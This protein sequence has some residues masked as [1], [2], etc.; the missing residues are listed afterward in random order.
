MSSTIHHGGPQHAGH[1][2]LPMQPAVAYP[3]PMVEDTRLAGHQMGQRSSYEIAAAAAASNEELYHHRP[4]HAR[5]YMHPAPP[6]N[7]A[8][9]VVTYSNDIGAPRGYEN[10]VTAANHRPYDP[11]ANAAYERYDTQACAP[12]QPQQQQLH[13]RPNMYYLGQTN[14]TPEDQ[15]RA[16]HQEA[17]AAQQHQMAM[18]AASAASMMKTEDGEGFD[19]LTTFSFV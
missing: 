4:E 5:G 15:E 12:L 3:M 9:P 19:F 10:A 18:A 13:S 16:Y 11:G 6:A 2:V 1:H 8:R 7:I 17:A 14:M